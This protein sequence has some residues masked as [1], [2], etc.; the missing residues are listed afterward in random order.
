MFKVIYTQHSE[1][2][3]SL[4]DEII[5]VKSL[6]WPYSYEEH[7]KWIR[8]NLK[9]NDIHVLLYDGKLALAYINLIAINVSVNFI[10]LNG[11]GI[12]NVCAIEKG[13]GWGKQLITQTNKYLIENNKVGLLFCKTKLVKFYLENEWIL[14]P[15]Q[16]IKLPNIKK[17]VISLGYNIPEKFIEI[18]Y[19]KILF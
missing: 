17:E 16:K 8:N 6:A 13:K 9:N 18:T 7:S 5:K 11:F 19:N 3:E 15:D 1:L 14:I 2:T 4:L 10:N 12:G